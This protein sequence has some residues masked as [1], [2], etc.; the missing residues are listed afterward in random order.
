MADDQVIID[1]NGR[2]ASGRGFQS[3]A[4]DY[5][6]FA[7]GM[8]GHLSGDRPL[9]YE[10]ISGPYSEL[11]DDLIAGC[12]QLGSMLSNAGTGQVVMADGSVEAERVGIENISRLGQMPA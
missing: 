4:S 3:L 7:S 11:M 1:A 8:R 10:E 5:T 2:Y 12:E 9:P 6:Q